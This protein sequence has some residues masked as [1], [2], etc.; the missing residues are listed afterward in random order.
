MS[1]NDLDGDGRLSRFEWAAMI[2]HT[3]PEQPPEPNLS[4]YRQTRQAV[5]AMF[6]EQDG[7]RDGYLSLGELVR[8]P[9][10]QFAC[11][12][13]NRDG[14]ISHRE[15]WRAMSRCPSHVTR[16]GFISAPSGPRIQP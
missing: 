9:L 16:I 6:D 11:M 4:N 1:A 12:D 7:D 15:I 3:W 13:R 8:E 10:A 14:R 5:L 2:S